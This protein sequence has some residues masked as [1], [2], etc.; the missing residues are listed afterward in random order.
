MHAEAR[1]SLSVMYGFLLTL[2]RVSGI[3]VCA[4]VPGLRDGSAAARTVLSLGLTFILLPVWPAVP[5]GEPSLGRMAGWIAAQ[6][7]FGMLA[8]AALALFLEGVQLA[9]QM[10]G[11]QAGYSFASTID[12]STQADT[13]TLQMMMQLFAGYLLFAFGMDRQLIR[14]LAA[15]M[16]SPAGDTRFFT[17]ASGEALIRLGGS[18]F[19]TGLRLAM[20]VLAL[21]LLL[22]IALAVLGRFH[23][24]MQLI[25]LSFPLK[26]L[27]GLTMLASILTLY[28]VALHKL[29][30]HALEVLMR[31]S[32]P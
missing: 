20:P 6:F 24:Q 15:G 13:S 14:I 22:D 8:G 16:G 11:L 12:P 31:L 19:T 17:A 1:L 9:A 23:Q 7:A 10:I 18:I 32:N 5:A 2:S 4:P 27:A 29:A 25:S 26:M 21:L 30:E 28:P 3:L